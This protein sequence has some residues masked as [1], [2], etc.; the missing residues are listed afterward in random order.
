MFVL[1][2]V[3]LKGTLAVVKRQLHIRPPVCTIRSGPQ[4]SDIT[5]IIR[6]KSR[7]VE[8]HHFLIGMRPLLLANEIP[9]C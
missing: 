8:F 1:L 4:S 3:Y 2:Y 5:A 6:V 7:N 9:K